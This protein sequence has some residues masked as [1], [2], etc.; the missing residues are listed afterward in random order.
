MGISR[1]AAFSYQAGDLRAQDVEAALGG[2]RL[3]L[4]GELTASGGTTLTA[5]LAGPTD[6]LGRLAAGLAPADSPMR[7]ME[8][9]GALSVELT[10]A[11][12]PNAD[13]TTIAP[14][15][16]IAS[17]VLDLELPS[18]DWEARAAG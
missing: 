14:V 6:D 3:H 9:A 12:S 17:A 16:G 2:T 13:P 18:L 7:D 11:G 4:D 1:P 15:T 10:A 5:R 8:A